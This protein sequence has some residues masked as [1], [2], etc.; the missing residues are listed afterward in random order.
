MKEYT[1]ISREEREIIFSLKLS[2]LSQV[3][4]ASELHRD[5]STISRELCRNKSLL[6]GKNAKKVKN[7]EDYHYLP[8]RADSMYHARRESWWRASPM[9]HPQVRDYV[10]SGLTEKGWSPDIISGKMIQDFPD[11]T[12]MRISHECIYQFIYSKA[13]EALHLKT[14]LLRSHKRRKEKTG[15]SVRWVSKTRIPGRIDI[16]ERPASVL[17]REEFWHWEGDSVLSWIKAWATLHTEVER[18]SRF[19]CV[20][21]IPQKT[22]SLTLEAVKD[23]FTPLPKEARK[24]DTY[25]NGTENVQHLEITASL[26]MAVYYAKP[27]HSWER[28]SNEHANG[29]IRRFFPK[30]TDFSMVSDEWLQEVITY[31]NNRPRRILWYRTPQEVFDE[32]IYLLS[33]RS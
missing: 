10:I 7:P 13:G 19:L 12:E 1:H 20:R 33:I 5:A 22:A 6:G 18:K 28:G 27:Y 14:F 32:E 25:D 4:I 16:S 8:D 11:D 30:G 29:M 21:K 24:S 3:A 9:D 15:R 23:I 2:G 17:T 26:W 31:I